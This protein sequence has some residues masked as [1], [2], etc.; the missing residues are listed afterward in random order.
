[1]TLTKIATMT[2]DTLPNDIFS[3]A[4]THQIISMIDAGKTDGHVTPISELVTPFVFSRQFTTAEDADEWKT[5]L[6]TNAPVDCLVS[7]II[8]DMAL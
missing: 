6:E 4:R 1:M 7:V 2:W 5:W 8:T 3:L